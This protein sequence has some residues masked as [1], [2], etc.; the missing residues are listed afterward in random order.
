M[1]SVIDVLI[2]DHLVMEEHGKSYELII[3]SSRHKSFSQSRPLT[4]SNF[5]NKSHY[6]R[7]SLSRTFLLSMILIVPN[8]DFHSQNNSADLHKSITEQSI[9]IYSINH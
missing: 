6:N 1:F 3:Q 2:K 5:E 8:C 7:E 4:I 9:S